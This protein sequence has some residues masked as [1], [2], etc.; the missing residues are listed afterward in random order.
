MGLN[1][2]GFRPEPFHPMNSMKGIMK[3]SIMMG[4][5]IPLEAAF[6]HQCRG[7]KVKAIPAAQGLLQL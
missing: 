4:Q 2:T 3:T 1:L 6:F 5:T 7:S